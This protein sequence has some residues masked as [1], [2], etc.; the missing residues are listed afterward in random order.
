MAHRI[1]SPASWL[2]SLQDVLKS[3]FVVENVGGGGG[4]IGMSRAARADADGYTL[5]VST[6]AYSVN[7]SLYDNLPYDPIKDFAAI[8]ELASS[9]NI[10]TVKPELGV[11]TLPDFIALVKKAPEKFN[12]ATPPVGTT[13]QLQAEVLKLR[14]GIK[15]MATVVHTGGGQALQALLSNSVQLSSGSLP[16]SHPQIKAGTIVGLAMTGE[17]RWHDL[18]DVPTMAEAG[19]KDFVFDTYTA[20]L[21]PAKTPPDI[22][23]RLEKE[24]L[25]IL[26]APD[27]SKKLLELGF[28]V[29]AKDGKGHMERVVKDVAFWKDIVKQ[30]GIK[31]PQAK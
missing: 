25:A 16:P 29:Q 11:K 24:T 17:K 14:A 23:A 6:N 1:S 5:L 4:N 2:P 30:A 8:A 21:A 18:P 28:T 15:G 10:W 7:P 31:L 26:K 3:S 9:P 27:M 19:F 22:V 12:V 20:L 13:P